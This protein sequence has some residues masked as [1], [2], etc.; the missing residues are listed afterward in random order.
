MCQCEAVPDSDARALSERHLASEL[1][2]R[3]LHVQAVA[4]ETARLCAALDLDGDAVVTAA[5]LHDLGYAP[6]LFDSGFHPL[7]AA[8]YLREHGW[9]E[10]VCCLVAHHS[11]AALQADRLGLGEQLRAEFRDI[12]GTARDVLWSADATTG[13]AGQRMSLGERVAEISERYGRDNLV[14]QCMTASRPALEAA[15]GRVATRLAGQNR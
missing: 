6:A 4:A 10:Q 2:Q 7:D 9:E 1:P 11:D 12:H 3:W 13:P 5:W 8:R 15:I 14:T